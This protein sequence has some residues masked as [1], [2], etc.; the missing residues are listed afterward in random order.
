MTHCALIETTSP[1]VAKL[2]YISPSQEFDFPSDNFGIHLL[3][4][5]FVSSNKAYES[6]TVIE[7]GYAIL[8]D[9]NDDLDNRSWGV[10]FH[11]DEVT[12][13]EV[14]ELENTIT[15]TLSGGRSIENIP[16]SYVTFSAFLTENGWAP[17]Q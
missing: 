12:S 7:E 5:G 10:S 15:V 8:T 13:H 2:R 17:P 9:T 6:L 1:H 16:M 3:K 14:G 11:I 4:K